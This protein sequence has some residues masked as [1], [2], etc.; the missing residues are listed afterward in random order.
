M[1]ILEQVAAENK[2]TYDT[3]VFPDIESGLKAVCD[4]SID[5]LAGDIP[6]THSGFFSVEFSHPYFHS[7]LQILVPE[8][9]ASSSLSFFT[10]LLDLVH[11]K[12]FWGILTVVL[13][14]T[15]FVY[16]FER[17]HNPDFPKGRKDGLAEAF[18]YVVTLALT[19]KSAYKGF[20]GVLGRLVMI[21]WIILGIVV[22]A[23]V[24]SS[25][26]SAMTIEKLK[27]KIHGPGDLRDKC[28]A[29]VENSAAQGYMRENGIYQQPF[30]S[31]D[32]AVQFMLTGGA[33]AVVD[34]APQV[35]TIDFKQPNIPVKVAGPIFSRC[36]YGF[37]F[38]IGSPLRLP[39]NRAL[40]ALNE[41]GS[42]ERIFISYFGPDNQP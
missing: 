6:V 15:L 33:D 18:Y 23:Y 28:V 8:K 27:G 9:T 37:A 29:V 22:V 25:I 2:W 32:E 12:M 40:T 10:D 34:G 11:L 39:F 24:T 3:V 31:L 14:L 41:N 26:T 35:Q 30:P 13:V 17:K 19:G 5:I 21:V 36:T 7:G 38:P 1:E 16:W 20:P 4:G 42:I